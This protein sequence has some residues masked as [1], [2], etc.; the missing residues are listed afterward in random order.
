[1]LADT[2]GTDDV[3]GKT[4][5]SG[6]KPGTEYFA[7]GSW[8]SGVPV[9]NVPLTLRLLAPDYTGADLDAVRSRPYPGDRR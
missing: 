2:A 8:C 7:R 9:V 6:T 4:T 5:A 1:M 3:P